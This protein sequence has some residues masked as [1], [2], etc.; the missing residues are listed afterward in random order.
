SPVTLALGHRGFTVSAVENTLESLEAAADAGVDLVEM[1]VMQTA[2]GK[3]IAMHDTSLGRLTGVN[4]EVKDL[5]FAEITAMTVRDRAGN[6]GRIPSFEAYVLRA[7]ELELPLLIE[8]KLSGAET[9]DHVDRL[10]A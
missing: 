10:I 6:E 2:D 8:I 3:F 4:A 7:A 9:D 5:T 1:D